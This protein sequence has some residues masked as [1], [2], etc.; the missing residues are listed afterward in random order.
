M[1]NI[2]ENRIIKVISKIISEQHLNKKEQS[3]LFLFKVNYGHV[4]ECAEIL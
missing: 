4:G 1:N 3:F 2:N